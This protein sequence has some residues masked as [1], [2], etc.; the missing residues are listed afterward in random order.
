MQDETFVVGEF[1]AYY[2]PYP[3]P[4]FQGKIFSNSSSVVEFL[5]PIFQDCMEDTEQFVVT[6]LSKANS[7]IHYTITSTGGIAGTLVDIQVILR[8][9]ILLNAKGI[10]LA[11]NHPSGNIKT[12]HT[13]HKHYY[14]LVS[15]AALLEIAVFRSCDY[16]S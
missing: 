10:V 1:R 7:I 12:I 16:Y 9:A 14:K 15:A 6:Y 4:T 11:H 8:H 5:R 2:K 13:R 3:N